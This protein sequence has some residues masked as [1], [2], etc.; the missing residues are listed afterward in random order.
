MSTDT[1]LLARLAVRIP[2]AKIRE[3]APIGTYDEIMGLWLDPSSGAPV[4]NN[5]DRPRPR[6]KK[7]DV[8][9]GEDNKGA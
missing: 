8:E 2:I 5:P 7:A 9:T 6:T 1:H 4:V 3:A